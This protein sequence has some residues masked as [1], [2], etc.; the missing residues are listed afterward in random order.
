M[1][2]ELAI[3]PLAPLAVLLLVGIHE[4]AGEVIGS[5]A[6]CTPLLKG[7]RHQD[8]DLAGVF[9]GESSIGKLVDTEAQSLAGDFDRDREGG[10]DLVPVLLPLEKALDGADVQLVHEAG[11]DGA[12]LE[13]AVVAD[14]HELLHQGDGD[15]D[16]GAE[17]GERIAYLRRGLK[18][19]GAE[20]SP[21]R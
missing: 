16:V 1:C 15:Q 12:G 4:A 17:V 13:K 9:G 5:M 18:P 7:S 21:V 2:S 8:V 3:K 6:C 19:R 11:F 14:D 10:V 20:Q